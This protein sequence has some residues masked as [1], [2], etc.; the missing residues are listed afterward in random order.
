MNI[1]SFII[2]VGDSHFG[3]PIHNLGIAI[4]I[5]SCVAVQ[6]IMNSESLAVSGL[7]KTYMRAW[8]DAQEAIDNLPQIPIL[9]DMASLVDNIQ[10]TMTTL[11][12]SDME[13]GVFAFTDEIGHLVDFMNSI[14]ELVETPGY[15]ASIIASLIVSASQVEGNPSLPVLAGFSIND[16]NPREDGE[17]ELLPFNG[18]PMIEMPCGL[19]DDD[20]N[21][22]PKHEATARS[23][24]KAKKIPDELYSSLPTADE[25][26]I[27]WERKA[28][29]GE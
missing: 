16:S 21:L 29:D 12:E 10:N 5:S 2:S 14:Q 1:V 28:I 17:R 11:L 7:Q 20:G 19:I 8:D 13:L 25:S 6:I 23:M 26:Q 24:V 3:I 22:G 18:K 15:H 27:L 9:A 4:R